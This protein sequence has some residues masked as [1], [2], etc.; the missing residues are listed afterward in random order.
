MQAWIPVVR[1]SLYFRKNV[2]SFRTHSILK[3]DGDF[4]SNWKFH[5]LRA[6]LWS[7]FGARARQ[8]VIE[9]ITV[10]YE[11]TKKTKE[12]CSPIGHNNTKHFLCPIRSR[13][14]R[15]FMEITRWGSVPRGS[16]ARTW[17]LSSHPFSRHDWLLVGL[18]GWQGPETTRRNLRFFFRE[19]VGEIM[20]MTSSLTKILLSKGT[21]WKEVQ[22]HWEYHL[23]E[24]CT[25]SIKEG[26]EPTLEVHQTAKHDGR[27]INI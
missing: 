14:P 18:R 15:E 25:M 2:F 4:I 3:S 21:V 24:R 23:V 20:L 5:W 6:V 27:S 1:S 8:A 7:L 19:Q 26:Q 16:F 12:N 11:L 22:C 13:H 17:K 9:T 10:V